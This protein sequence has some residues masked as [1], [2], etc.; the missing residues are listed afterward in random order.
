MSNADIKKEM[1]RLNYTPADPAKWNKMTTEEQRQVLVRKS[2]EREM[3]AAKGLVR[4]FQ[5]TKE[6]KAL[7]EDLQAA[8]TRICGK[9]GGGARS[10]PFMDTLAG[11]FPKVKT[12]ISELDI[13]KA[14]KMG[15]GEFRKRVREA[16]K[17]ADK[18]A[19]LWIEF[20]ETKEAWTLLA[21]GGDKP[22]GFL[23]KD[24]D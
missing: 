10:N 23:G 5:A 9:S 3:V 8:I 1:E 20:D 17:S 19:R 24:I 2:N 7:P 6:F 13:F 12:S 18:D 21:I 22:A 14:T 15:R 4:K 11:L 16:L